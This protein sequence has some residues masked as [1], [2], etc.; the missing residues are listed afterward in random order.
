MPIIS[1]SL[2][3]ADFGNLN[4]DIEMLNRSEAEWLHLDVMDGLFVPNISFGFPVIS[5]IRKATDKVLDTHFMIVDPDR[6]VS[7]SRDSGVDIMNVHLETCTHLGRVV[8]HIHQAGMKAGVTLNPASPT[9]MLEDVIGDVDMILLMSVN[10]G[11]AAQKF[12]P[13]TL[14]KLRQLRCM[15]DRAGCDVKIEI[16]GG[17]N[18][19]TGRQAVEA[20]ADIL[21]SGNCIFSSPDPEETIRQLKR[22]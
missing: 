14:D 7:Q 20:G 3:S 1:P 5:A 22:L 10:P 13:R 15:I 16:D 21:V 6:Y 12:I 9:V 19:E 11:F 8:Q 18:L 17:I 4:R 2:L